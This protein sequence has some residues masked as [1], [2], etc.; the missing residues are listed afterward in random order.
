MAAA[1]RRLGAEL[2][3]SLGHAEPV[4]AGVDLDGRGEPAP[5]RAAV[6]RPIA[7]L[8]EAGEDRAQVE[9]R[10]VGFRPGQEPVE[11]VDGGARLHLA[12]GAALVN[13]G[14]EE[15]L[16]ALVGER[17]RDRREAHAVGVGLDDAGAL[18]APGDLVEPRPVRAQ[19][20]E[21][22]GEDGARRQRN[23]GTCPRRSG[24]RSCHGT[25]GVPCHPALVDQPS[26]R[27]NKRWMPKSAD[28]SL[29][30]SHI[31]SL[32]SMRSPACRRGPDRRSG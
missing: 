2:S 20:R 13:G 29:R 4:H 32:P 7:H 3:T 24:A 9:A 1:G 12:R 21:I 11:H 5:A 22:D 15:R 23:C 27:R 25:N 30:L 6:A 31:I 14:D 10:V 16:A 18:G 26:R 17:T 8:G 19:G 28:M